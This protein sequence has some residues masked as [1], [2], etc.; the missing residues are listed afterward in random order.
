MVAVKAIV[1]SQRRRL[2]E[3]WIW[4]EANLAPSEPAHLKMGL[5]YCLDDFPPF[6]GF[7]FEGAECS[8][9]CCH[10]FTVIGITQNLLHGWY[11]KQR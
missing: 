1:A 10:D 11:Q 6:R 3:L 9:F 5:Y 7:E 8:L 4:D 2:R